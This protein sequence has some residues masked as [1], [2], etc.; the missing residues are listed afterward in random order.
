MLTTR[1]TRKGQVT[2]PAEIR[3]RLHLDEGE[4]FLVREENGKIV[5]ESQLD[6]VRR[7]AGVFTEYA[8]NIPPLEPAE[9][10]EIAEAAIAE[11]GYQTLLQIERDRLANLSSGTKR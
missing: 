5:L 8:R 2:I 10:R 4:V 1:M 9:V 7:T 11:E 3:D 6:L